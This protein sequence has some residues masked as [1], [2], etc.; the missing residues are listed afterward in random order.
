MVAAA[1]RL[2]EEGCE[3][4]PLR[5]AF[6]RARV[7]AAATAVVAVTATAAA[8]GRAPAISAS[9]GGACN[10]A[11]A[12]RLV[13]R[14]HLGNAGFTSQPVAQVLCGP[15]AGPRS[16]A[17]A[18]SLSTPGCGGSIG[19]AVFR[20]AGG[21]WRRVFLTNNGA[22]LARAAARIRTWQGVLA[23]GDPHCF[24]SAWRTRDWHWNGRRLVAGRWHP[25]GPPPSP[26]PGRPSASPA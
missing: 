10:V 17:M 19:W 23:P 5:R 2:V 12:D 16:H 15:F 24:P 9:T 25:S 14:Q 7:V 18:V 4:V 8:S 22:F 1:V 11:T 20:N 3:A 6:T 26:L 13:E 21:A